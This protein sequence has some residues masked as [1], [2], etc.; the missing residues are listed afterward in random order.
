[1]VEKKIDQVVFIRRNIMKRNGSIAA[2]VVIL[3]MD[4]YNYISL[5]FYI[6]TY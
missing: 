6:F 5:L 2:A 4:E 3:K 1:M